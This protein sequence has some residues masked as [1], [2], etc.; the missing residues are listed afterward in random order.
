VA[1]GGFA[2]A[3]IANDVPLIA[4]IAASGMVSDEDLAV[5]DLSTIISAALARWEAAG[6]TVDQ[7]DVL[8]GAIFSVGDL[9]G[10][11][12]GSTNEH[13]I[14]IDI[15]AAGY[16]WFVDP[17]PMDDNEFSGSPMYQFDLLTVVMHEMGHVLGFGDIHDASAASD[18]M[19]GYLQ[20]GERRL[21]LPVELTGTVAQVFDNGGGA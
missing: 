18:L 16:G 21:P 10:L 9:A 2:R 17:T 14:N 8:R 5:N 15:N 6:I 1:N 19:Y 7:V 12:L 13:A 20:L 3:T 4:D 11:A